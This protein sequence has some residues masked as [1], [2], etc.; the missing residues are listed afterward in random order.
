MADL[1]DYADDNWKF[2]GDLG[3]SLGL[4]DILSNLPPLDWASYQPGIQAS[5]QVDIDTRS[6]VKF[7]YTPSKTNMFPS[8]DSSPFTAGFD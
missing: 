7:H 8:R 2:N 4:P 1:P 6:Y 3:A 5:S